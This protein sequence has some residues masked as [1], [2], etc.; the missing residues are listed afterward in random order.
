MTWR[1]LMLWF[2][3]LK[4][5]RG[6][7]QESMSPH[8]CAAAILQHYLT[9]L[10]ISFTL[11]PAVFCK[12]PSHANTYVQLCWHSI[13]TGLWDNT[14]LGFII[15]LS[16]WDHLAH[17]TLLTVVARQHRGQR[18]GMLRTCPARLNLLLQFSDRFL[19]PL[20]HRCLCLR[21]ICAFRHSRS[22]T[23]WAWIAAE[24][25]L[26]VHRS[27]R[28]RGFHEHQYHEGGTWPKS[29]SAHFLSQ[30]VAH[31]VNSHIKWWWCDRW[32]SWPELHC[33]YSDHCPHVVLVL[34]VCECTISTCVER[35][36][37][38]MWIIVLWL[39]FY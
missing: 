16:L 3:N 8:T 29:V 4:W 19:R 15:V 13:P 37:K 17:R 20:G 35:L 14:S 25:S 30:K 39:L 21:P 27:I 36:T 26:S 31:I 24:A 5:G 7:K 1:W 38:L 18:R 33:S 9:V 32:K 6:E 11:P 12:F 22:V 10:L 23:D 34:W 28:T 2:R